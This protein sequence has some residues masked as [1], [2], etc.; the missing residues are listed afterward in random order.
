MR[1]PQNGWFGSGLLKWM[2]T[3]GTPILGNHHTCIYI[4]I[5]FIYIYIYIYVYIYIYTVYIYIYIY[6]CIYIYTYTYTYVY[7]YIYTHSH[8]VVD[9]NTIICPV[10]LLLINTT[11]K[12]WPCKIT[13]H[14]IPWC[15]TTI[16]LDFGLIYGDLCWSSGPIAAVPS[17]AGAR[18]IAPFNFP[19][20]QDR[21]EDHNMNKH[22]QNHNF[23]GWYKP[24]KMGW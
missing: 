8:E 19:N 18:S 5:C 7:V 13:F 11:T 14:D 24:S 2:M 3:G 23:Y 6:I 1:N 21:S 22:P 4:Y 16:T 10:S 12:K 17:A 15:S 9:V 20:P